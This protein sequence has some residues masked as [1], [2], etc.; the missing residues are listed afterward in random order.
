MSIGTCD[1]CDRS[2]VPVAHLTDTTGGDVTACFLCQ[3][4]TDPDPYGEREDDERVMRC[5]D[6]GGD[7]SFDCWSHHMAC[8]ACKGR[9]VYRVMLAPV[10][11]ADL[12]ERDAEESVAR[13]LLHA[14]AEAA[15]LLFFIGAASLIAG[16]LT[17]VV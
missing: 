2:D 12:E 7:G 16:L 1:C 10:T 17:G 13:S 11:L 5:E 3:G 6:C 8:P 9:G 4:D 14:A 15:S